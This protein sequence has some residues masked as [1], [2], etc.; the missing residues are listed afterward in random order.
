MLEK[1]ILSNVMTKLK[2]AMKRLE[3]ISPTI[4]SMQAKII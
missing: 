2:H 3:N 4:W 1:D